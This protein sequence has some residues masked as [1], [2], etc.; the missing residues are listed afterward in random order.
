MANDRWWDGLDGLVLD[1]LPRGAR[2]VDVGC[3]DGELVK[4]L[5]AAGID[6]VGVDPKAPAHPRL[7]RG[8]LEDAA[9]IGPFDAATAVMSLHHADLAAVMEALARLV[10]VPG[11]LFVSELAW[12]AYDDAC[13]RWLARHDPS[14]ADHSVAR[15]RREHAGLHTSRDVAAALASAFDLEPEMPRPYLA[16][17]LERP[18]LEADERARIDAGDIPA[19]GRWYAGSR[20]SGPQAV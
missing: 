3:G 4:R 6:A 12:E 18:D 5:A 15:W 17:M 14:A 16:R 10:P 13:V 20:R 9:G 1:A 19:L 2:V 11:R 7:I 8:R